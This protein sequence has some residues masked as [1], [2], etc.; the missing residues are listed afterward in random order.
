MGAVDEGLSQIQLAAV[1]QILS[2]LAQYT[3]ERLVFEPRLKSPMT[4]LVWRVAPRQVRPWRARA[5]HPEHA[6]NDI[7]GFLPRPAAFLRRPLQLLGGETALDRVPLL[8]GESTFSLR[9]E[10]GSAVDPRRE[11]PFR[12]GHLDQQVMRSALADAGHGST[13]GTAP[14]AA[15]RSAPGATSL[16]ARSGPRAC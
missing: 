6:V 1:A 11:D 3:L 2:E 12:N 7:A 4:C 8:I 10:I 9:S 15:A 14:V 5:E 16:A 13:I